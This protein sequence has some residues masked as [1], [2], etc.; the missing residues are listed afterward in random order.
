[1]VSI[2][3][4]E[5]GTTVAQL[6]VGIEP[7]GMGV[8]PD[9]KLTVATSEATS[10]AHFI[11]NAAHKVIANVLVDTRPRVAEWTRDGKHVWV[12]SEIGGTVSVINPETFKID[13]KFGFEI[14]G[15]DADL[16][17][18][19]GVQ[20]SLDGKR[21]FIALSHANRVAVVDTETYAVIR[22]IILGQRPWHLAIH[23]DGKTLYVANGLTN[24][25][26][27]IDVATEKPIK[28]VP[29]GRL[30]WGVAVMP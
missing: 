27:I 19:I 1:M 6:D 2:V 7:E 24:D 16:I 5:D 23:P 3:N 28:S 25:M 13:K 15:V 10:M 14:P 22:Y 30:P 29:V 20:F 8:S 26:T 11:D 9:N 21:A 4:F 12:T 18:P 17:Q